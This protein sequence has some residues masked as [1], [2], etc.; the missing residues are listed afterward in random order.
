MGTLTRTEIAAEIRANLGGRTDLDTLL[1]TRINLSQRRIARKHDWEELER[2]KVDASSATSTKSYDV[3][4]FVGESAATGNDVVKDIHTIRLISA[5]ESRRLIRVTPA[6]ADMVIPYPENSATGKPF[7]YI[8]YGNYFEMIRIP[9]DS[10]TCYVRWSKYP[11][12]MDNDASR[13]DLK[14]KD[15][16]IIALTTSWSFSSLKMKEE[17]AH[18]F[19]IAKDLINDA[20]LDDNVDRDLTLRPIEEL[21]IRH[22][23]GNYWNDPFYR[24]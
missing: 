19:T 7:W 11:D 1:S 13:S 9:D 3:A 8:W 17:A 21:G 24:G 4:T 5:E 23:T 2:T 10:Y 14:N 20:M 16:A 18:W 6:Q 22:P 12:D 15:D